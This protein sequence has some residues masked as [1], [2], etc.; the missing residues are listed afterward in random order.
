LR[1]RP[2]TKVLKEGSCK[3]FG[4]EFHVNGPVTAN[5]RPPYVIRRCGS[6]VSWWLAAERKLYY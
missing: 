5:A 2:K 3:R 4:S 6:T 1:K